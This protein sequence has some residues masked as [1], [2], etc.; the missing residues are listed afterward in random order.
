M[1][2]THSKYSPSKLKQLLCCPGSFK[3]C[4][5]FPNT[6]NAAAERGTMLHEHME[7]ICHFLQTHES[8]EVK[9][10]N[11]NDYLASLDLAKED[12]ASL[13]FCWAALES[14]LL[15]VHETAEWIIEKRVFLS[16]F[17][18]D[19]VHGTPD[20]RIR[21]YV[22]KQSH[23]IDWKFGFTPVDVVNNAQL[24]AYGAGEAAEILDSDIAQINT[25]ILQPEKEYAGCAAYDIT[26]LVDWVYGPLSAAIFLAEL[27]TPP[28]RPTKEG[29]TWCLARGI[30]GERAAI[31]NEVAAARFAE[32]PADLE[33]EEV[34]ELAEKIAHAVAF[35]KDCEKH[36]KSTLLSGKPVP[37]RKLVRKN[38]RRTWVDQDATIAWL[39]DNTELEMEDI[40]DVACLSPA[41]IEKLD[42][43]LKKNAD[44][45]KLQ[46]IPEGEL[47]VALESSPKPAVEIS[48][49]TAFGDLVE[50]ETL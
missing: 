20:L 18:L 46:H 40:A 30:C 38:K 10:K 21:D 50:E 49:A 2:E 41:K 25:Y 22:N 27:D 1:P 8:D 14:I 29:C 48:P 3:K 26:E 33:I 23:V 19:D 13:R 47:V 24:K 32:R 34:A 45:T 12:I 17:G 15:E 7:N 42:K 9:T 28:V 44:Y 5:D 31:A 6:T 11:V 43:S 4:Q 16:N 37:G 35:S 36:I 39:L